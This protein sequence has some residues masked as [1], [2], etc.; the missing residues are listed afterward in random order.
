MKSIHLRALGLVTAIAAL[1]LT[2]VTPESAQAALYATAAG[3]VGWVT[4]RRPGDKQ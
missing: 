2:I 3:L 1:A 4:L